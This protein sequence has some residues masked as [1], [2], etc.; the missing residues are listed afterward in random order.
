M[1][2]KKEE[3]KKGKYKYMKQQEIKYIYFIFEL[4]AIMNYYKCLNM[5]ESR[6]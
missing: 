3:Q 4:M 1:K 2:I 6:S 5:Y